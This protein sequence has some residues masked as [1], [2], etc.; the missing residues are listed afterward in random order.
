MAVR[1]SHVSKSYGEG[2]ARTL[3]LEDI[4][5][6]VLP[7][8]FLCIIGESGCGKSTLLQMIAGF[9]RP[10]LGEIYS[11]GSAITG[12]SFQRSI[13]F[14]EGSLLPWLT[15]EKNISLGLEIRGDYENRK[16]RVA[17]LIDLMGL[18]GFERHYPAELS[19]G[20]AQRV[21]IARSL[22]NDARIMLLDEPF[23]A[24]DAFTRMRLQGELLRIWR[25]EKLTMVF[26]TH[27][28]DEAVFLGTRILVMSARP[29][30]IARLFNIALRYPRDRTGADFIRLRGLI[31]KEFLTLTQ[32]EN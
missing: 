4:D 24:L 21:A 27:D 25:Q 5:F 29:G 22:I 13:V 3:A 30:R 32:Q 20:M 10:S 31:G 1:L 28:I 14:Q 6:D 23:G 18:R 12:P 7:G 9:E 16:S 2:K 8:E 17:Q 11:D 19:G 26:V 15:V